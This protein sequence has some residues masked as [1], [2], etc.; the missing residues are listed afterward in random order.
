MK[1]KI[2]HKSTFEKTSRER[3][4]K[5][6]WAAISVF[7][8]KGYEAASVQDIAQKAGISVGSLYSYFSS[9]EDL[10]KA[11][12]EMGYAVLEQIVTEWN[13][14]KED[15]FRSAMTTLFRMTLE[16]SRKYPDLS[17]LYLLLTT[18]SLNPFSEQLSKEM[19]I[20]FRSAYAHLLEN[21][22]EKGE[23]RSDID[24]EMAGYFIDNAA[25]MLQFSQTSKY[26]QNR[27]RQYLGLSEDEE[28]PDDRIVS[29]LVNYICDGLTHEEK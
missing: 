21:A 29:A 22:R 26:Y 13:P 7:S 24:L 3:Q 2:Y 10:F 15:S 8:Q 9:K 23:L 20:S 14:Q 17:K 5:V 27:L 1:R 18:D 16:Y 25:V 11:I 4:I 12:A 19:E 28:M 6:Y